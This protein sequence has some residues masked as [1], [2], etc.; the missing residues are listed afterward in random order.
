M[1]LSDELAKRIL[2]V[3]VA[4]PYEIWNWTEEAGAPKTVLNE[5][6]S[7]DF[8]EKINQIVHLPV[9]M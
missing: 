9:C 6:K 3:G 7:F 4:T 1:S 5:W 8:K 2:G